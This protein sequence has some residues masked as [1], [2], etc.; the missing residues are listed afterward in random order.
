VADS[1]LSTAAA[2]CHGQLMTTTHIRRACAVAFIGLMLT[3]AVAG[4]AHAQSTGAGAG[5]V[6]F[7]PF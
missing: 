2:L 4:P 5:K 7:N 3:G 6:T 1:P